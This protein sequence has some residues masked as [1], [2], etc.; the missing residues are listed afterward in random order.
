MADIPPG[1]ADPGG[2]QEFAQ[3]SVAQMSERRQKETGL[4]IAS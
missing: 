1:G 4:Y 3:P 2:V